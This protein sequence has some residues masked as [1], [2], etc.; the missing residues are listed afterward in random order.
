M[1]ASDR[2]ISP[3]STYETFAHTRLD[4]STDILEPEI[5]AP[6]VQ[7]TEKTH[8]GAFE[9]NPGDFPDDIIKDDK[10]E[11]SQLDQNLDQEG[12]GDYSKGLYCWSF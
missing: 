4:A 2:I 5:F 9:G 3:R 7:P 6:A 8:S 11:K 10:H 12:T 1:L